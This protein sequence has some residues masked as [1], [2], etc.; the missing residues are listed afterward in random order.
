MIEKDAKVLFEDNNR[1]IMKVIHSDGSRS[2]KIKE[3][4]KNC[5]YC[6]SKVHRHSGKL[7]MNELIPKLQLPKFFCHS[8]YISLMKMVKLIKT[9]DK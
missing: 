6:N 4:Q 3:M 7:Y 2:Y 9:G 8:F 1:K 5:F